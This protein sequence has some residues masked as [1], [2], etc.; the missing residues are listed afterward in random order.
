M[1]F[2]AYS[3]CTILVSFESDAAG[4]ERG[5]LDAALGRIEAKTLVIGLTT[6]IVFPADDMRALAS[7]IPGA[8]YAEIQS[9]FGHDGFLVEH[10]QLN[11]LMKPFMEV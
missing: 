4:D 8:V 10:D 6:D 7:R 9:P 5:G 1:R 2:D 11:A 3:D